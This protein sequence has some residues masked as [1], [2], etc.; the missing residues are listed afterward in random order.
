MPLD[1]VVEG[2]LTINMTLL[3]LYLHNTDAS[4]A[5]AIMAD[6]FGA[7]EPG[8]LNLVELVLL[9]R[10]NRRTRRRLLAVEA[11]WRRLRR[12]GDDTAVPRWYRTVQQHV[13]GLYQQ[14]RRYAYPMRRTAATHRL[15][16]RLR[17]STRRELAYTGAVQVELPTLA[18]R[19][20]EAASALLD[21][22]RNE[23][24][25]LWVDNWFLERYGT[26]PAR[27]VMSC[28]VTAMAVLLLSS[29]QEGPAQATRSHRLPAFPGHL[30]LHAMTIRL[31][32]VADDAWDSLLS[33][34]DSV[35]DLL[36][37][38]LDNTLVRVPLDIPR[39][40]R[41]SLQWRAFSLTGNRLS[42]NAELMDVFQDIRQ[43]QAHVGTD[44]LLLVDEKVHYALMRVLFSQ[45]F[46]KHDVHRW[47]SRVPTL[48]GAWHAYK[49]TLTLVHR[50]FFPIFALLEMTGF[51]ALGA[52]VRVHRK[53]LYLEKI[54]AALLLLATPLRAHVDRALRQFPDGPT[55]DVH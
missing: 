11:E 41:R 48:Y 53:I 38:P 32:S 35:R 24:V 36:A 10:G 50:Q 55:Q 26:N 16:D 7:H 43:V 6:A 45:P 46:A 54:C 37:Y 34:G 1:A 44:L 18:S 15:T 13:L 19:A 2:E 27:P 4:S 31:G 21:A 33:L 28:D 9:V 51:P 40:H 29:T 52:T 22:L 14:L 17:R 20:T 49:H 25:V 47:M 30:T 12:L 42:N 23:H 39:E 5:E 3:R 8:A